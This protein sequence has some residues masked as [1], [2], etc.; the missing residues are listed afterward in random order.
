MVEDFEECDDLTDVLEKFSLLKSWI[1][2]KSS[3]EI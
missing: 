3:R 1:E 2:E